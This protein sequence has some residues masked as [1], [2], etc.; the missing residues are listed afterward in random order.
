MLQQYELINIGFS[1]LVLLYGATNCLIK[2]PPVLSD[3]SVSVCACFI[4]LYIKREGLLILSCCV[5]AGL[6]RRILPSNTDL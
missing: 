1:V 6:Q 5:S 2:V 3:N 4:F